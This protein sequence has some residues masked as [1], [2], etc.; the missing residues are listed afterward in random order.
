MATPTLAEELAAFVDGLAFDDIPTPV[1]EAAL[2]HF[3]DTLGV[4]MAGARSSDAGRAA[5]AYAEATGG[6]PEATAVSAGVRLPAASAAL[7]NGTYAHALDFDDTHL[8]SVVHPS[9]PMVPAVLALAEAQGAAGRELITA[10][11]AAWEVNC[12]LSMA[13]YDGELRNSVFFEH[14]LHATAIV[15]AVSAA[16]ACAK[17]LGLGRTG[18]TNAFA[19]ACSMGAGLTESNRAG[20][21]IKQLHG[22]WAAH[23]AVAAASLA[24]HGITGPAS[25][26]EGRFGFFEAYCRDQWQPR[27]VTDALGTRWD[28]LSISFKPFPCNHFTHAVA[29]AALELRR[30]GLGPEDVAMVR[31]GTAG[32]SWRTIGD[33]IEQKRRP[34]DGYAA[35]FSGPWVFASALVGGGGLGVGLED[36]SARA[37][38]DPVRR[39]LAELAEV[40]VDDECSA[41]FPTQFPAVVTVRTNAGAE[42]TSRVMANLGGPARPLAAS[43]VRRKLDMT[44]GSQAA[45]LSAA[46]A[47]LP[48]A[49]GVGDVIAATLE[50]RP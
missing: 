44:A 34:S 21:T 30:D 36:F 43:D 40:Y 31:I 15:G 2:L 3:L 25:V 11:V 35:R 16:G 49:V 46:V 17:L 1:V 6:S 24:A 5:L 26:F 7:A 12:R 48:E 18:I 41:V 20:G 22:G 9:A 50:S 10:L 8:P 38:G 23:C 33:P 37:L 45:A 39:R 27:A 19:V 13:Q 28:T 4:S 32:P 29:E 42:K 47:A 14:G